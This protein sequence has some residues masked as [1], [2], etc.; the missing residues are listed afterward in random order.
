[1]DVEGIGVV[2][3]KRL[4]ILVVVYCLDSSELLFLDVLGSFVVFVAELDEIFSGDASLPFD[5]VVSAGSVS[6]NLQN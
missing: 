5:A 4:L 2:S 6:K 1:M 3:F